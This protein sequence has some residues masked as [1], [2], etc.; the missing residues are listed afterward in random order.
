MPARGS[1]S[2]LRTFLIADVRGYTRYTQQHGDE[3]AAALATGFADIVRSVVSAHEGRLIELRGDE[4]LVVFQSAR[5]ALQAALGVQAAVAEKELPRGVGIGVDAGEAVPVGKGYRGGALNMAARLCS[6]ARPGGVLASEA[7]VHLARTVPGVR[8]LQGR[9]ERLKGI[10]HPVRVVEVVPQESPVALLRS[11]TR[12]LR[13]RRWPIAVVAGALVLL[14]VAAGILVARGGGEPTLSSLH[15]VA[16]FTS[17][18]K[19]AASVPTGVDTF[20]EKYMDGFVWSLDDGGTLVKIDPRKEEVV[21]AVPIG[22]DAGWTVGGG[23]VWVD[24]ANKPEVIRVNAQYGSTSRI[25]LP[26]LPD[27]P[28]NPTAIAYGAGSLWIS[29][30]PRIL[31]VDPATGKVHATIP[32]NDAHLLTFGDG[33]LYATTQYNGDFFK[34]DP[35]SNTV[36]WRAHIHPWISDLAAAEGWV[37]LT[38]DSDAGVYRFTETDGSQSGF[39]RTGDGSG[40]LAFGAGSVWSGTGAQAPSRA[41]IQSASR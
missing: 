28:Q 12:R 5:Q 9:V 6:L 19:L 11:V 1:A 13:G 23:S 35:A 40:A 33:A 36:Q 22:A 15:T 34:V 32:S 14:A 2:T 17:D 8:Y 25:H 7:V 24:D 20:D 27:G 10:E 31:R 38:V 16:A 3:A 37:W 21:Q 26:K 30:G 41:W 18:G 4:A 29:Q 39:V